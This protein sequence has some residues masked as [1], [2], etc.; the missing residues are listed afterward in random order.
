MTF[1]KK[2]MAAAVLAVIAALGFTGVATAKSLADSKSVNAGLVAIG[3]ADEI[4]R[5]C[6]DINARMVK[7]YTYLNSLERQA[8]AEGF[9]QSEI[10]AYVDDKAQ[11]ARLIEVAKKYMASKGVDGSA[12]SYCKLGHQEIA[13]GT[14]VG[15]LL[16]E[17]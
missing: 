14:K 11:K 5:N 6:P 2:T 17:K 9:S 1:A 4:R 12:E 8:K 3:V 10:D 16:R 13:G 15:A 7:A